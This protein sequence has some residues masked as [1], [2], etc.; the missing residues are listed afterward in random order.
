[1]DAVGHEKPRPA[2]PS[3]RMVGRGCGAWEARWIISPKD[4]A[5]ASSRRERVSTPW[6][7]R[8]SA[9][10]PSNGSKTDDWRRA[11]RG[12]SSGEVS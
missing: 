8:S 3:G 4:L 2:G 12:G 9:S 11:T 6:R 5:V 7:Q 1:L 10:V